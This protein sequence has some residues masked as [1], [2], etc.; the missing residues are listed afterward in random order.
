MTPEY[1][2]KA[3]YV[4]G[5]IYFQGDE[6]NF[7]ERHQEKRELN[8]E[9]IKV[10]SYDALPDKY[11]ALWDKAEN[12]QREVDFKMQGDWDRFV[13]TEQPSVLMENVPA[14]TP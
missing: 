4:L 14:Q 10:D 1:D 7:E 5:S 2:R 8:A 9:V 12:A 6:T 3:A 13:G 11:K